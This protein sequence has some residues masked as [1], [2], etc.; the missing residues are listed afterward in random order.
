M[1]IQNTGMWVD[2]IDESHI[3]MAEYYYFENAFTDEEI[4]LI[5]EEAMKV[6]PTVGKTGRAGSNDETFRKSE[7]RW[8]HGNAPYTDGFHW[9]RFCMV[10]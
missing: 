6:A 1:K 3:D 9:R 8:L 4:K 5:Q 10:I 7:I 2:G